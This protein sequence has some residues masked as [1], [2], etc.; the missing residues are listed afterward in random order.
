MSET[1]NPALAETVLSPNSP[2]K[3][4][5]IAGSEQITRTKISANW[6]DQLPSRGNPLANEIWLGLRAL[7]IAIFATSIRFV[8]IIPVL[9]LVFIPAII[10]EGWIRLYLQSF[11]NNASTSSIPYSCSVSAEDGQII[12]KRE[13]GKRGYPSI[14]VGLSSI[15]QLPLLIRNVEFDQSLVT[16]RLNEINENIATAR[17]NN[18]STDTVQAIQNE[19]DIADRCSKNLSEIRL[20]LIQAQGILPSLQDS[21]RDLSLSIRCMALGAIGALIGVFVL[22]S[23]IEGTRCRFPPR[24]D[25][26]FPLRTDAG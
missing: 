26:G 4:A 25:P 20:S 15:P 19:A 17:A 5:E 24:F 3:K 22:T 23:A 7:V 8:L 13:G 2:N 1:V 6:I 10:P 14:D 11:L 18:A 9:V 16:R 12:I 21:L